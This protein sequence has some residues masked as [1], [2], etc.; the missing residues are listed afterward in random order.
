MPA[1]K[2]HSFSRADTGAM[3]PPLGAEGTPFPQRLKPAFMK[4]PSGVP[5]AVPFQAGYPNSG[6]ALAYTQLSQVFSSLFQ[7]TKQ[8]TS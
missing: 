8:N 7:V 4:R 3:L 2:G 5:E 1:L 6:I